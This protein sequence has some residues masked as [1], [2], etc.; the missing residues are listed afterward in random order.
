MP[1]GGKIKEVYI[2]NQNLMYS[3]DKK[4]G[5]ATMESSFYSKRKKK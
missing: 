1:G 5:N 2:D 4:N 3:E